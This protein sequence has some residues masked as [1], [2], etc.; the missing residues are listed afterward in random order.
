MVLNGDEGGTTRTLGTEPTVATAEKS[1]SGSYS[2]FMRYG[3]IGCAPV[4]IWIVC[5]SAGPARMARAAMTPVAPGR[6]STRIV[7]PSSYFK[8][9]PRAR[10]MRSVA[11]PGAAPVTTLLSFPSGAVCG[12][13]AG[14]DARVQAASHN[15]ICQDVRRKPTL[16]T[17]L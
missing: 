4:W 16:L 13:A 12:V 9:S 8:V 10:A 11:L 7:T 14:G 1:R 17:S 5:P 2:T 15:G 6:F 3:T